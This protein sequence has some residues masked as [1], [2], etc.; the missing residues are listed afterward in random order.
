[1]NGLFSF[2]SRA[3]FRSEAM[4]SPLNGGFVTST[5]WVGIL[6]SL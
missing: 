4:W 3:K 6:P 1:M 2:P 5:S